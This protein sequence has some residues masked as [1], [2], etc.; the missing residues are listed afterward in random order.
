[1]VKQKERIM[2]ASYEETSGFA[3]VA[4]DELRAVNGGLI[5]PIL[6]SGAVGPLGI[7]VTVVAAGILIYQHVNRK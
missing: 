4:D 6:G 5:V 1:M 7:A 3:P 2:V